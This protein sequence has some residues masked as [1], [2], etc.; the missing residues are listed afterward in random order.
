MCVSKSVVM[1]VYNASRWLDDTLQSILAQTF[2]GTLQL[3]IYND[4]STD[5]SMELIATYVPRFE[6]QGI[7][8]VC[9]GHNDPT[10]KG[11]GYGRTQA[12]KQS[13]GCFICVLDADDIMHPERIKKQFE[14]A[15]H[16]PNT[17]IGSGF[18]RQPE[19]STER[20]TRWCNTLSHEQLYTQ[21]KTLHIETRLAHCILP[22]LGVHSIWPYHN[23]TNMVL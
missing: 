10:P 23:P 1:T 4:G 6:A 22:F 9:S 15:R 14:A 7:Q 8:V 20:Y 12:I 16:H 21:V 19:D 13:S 3:S 2:T 18:V 17:L 11:P 5:T